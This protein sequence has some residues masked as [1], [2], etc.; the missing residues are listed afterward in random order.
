MYVYMY[1]SEL[2]YLPKSFELK[3]D[4]ILFNIFKNRSWN[5]NY[6]PNLKLSSLLLNLM[7]SVYVYYMY[8]SFEQPIKNEI[9]HVI[10]MAW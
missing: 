4:Y 3:S 10:L 6:S 1:T 5:I 7:Y 2:L 8:Y 9:I